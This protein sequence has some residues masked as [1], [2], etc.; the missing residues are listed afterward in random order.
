MRLSQG[1]HQ[2][3]WCRFRLHTGSSTV[4]V[5]SLLEATGFLKNRDSKNSTLSFLRLLGSASVRQP[6][7]RARIER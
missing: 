3:S 2:V 1:L 5:T 6:K 7:R 4:S